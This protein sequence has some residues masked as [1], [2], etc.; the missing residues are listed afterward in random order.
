MEEARD[1]S[2]LTIGFNEYPI[3]EHERKAIK[4]CGS[5]PK[6]FVCYNPEFSSTDH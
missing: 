2:L 6:R 5:D 1:G 3:P 4:I